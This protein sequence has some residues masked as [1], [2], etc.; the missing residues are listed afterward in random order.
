MGFMKIIVACEESQA[1]T[2]AFRSRGHEAYS[3]DLQECSGGYPEWHIQ[4]DALSI[5]YDLSYKWDMMIA[6]PPC[7]YLTLTG[8]RWFNRDKFRWKAV[9][10]HILRERAKDFF[11]KLWEAPISKI[12]IENPMGYMNPVL[13]HSQI[14]QPFYFGE[15]F[16]KQTCLWIKN[17]PLL[18]H[19]EQDT[20]FGDKQSHVDA[21]EFLYCTD[22]K[23]GKLKKQP[24]W[25]AQA[26]NIKND[27]NH[28]R[29]KIR[30]KTFDGI[31][32]AMAEQWG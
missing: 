31:A 21:G 18:R 20:L 30:S 7:T 2:K 4:G 5:V 12:A 29:A 15:S 11:W 16:S 27:N 8:N 28:T 10:R 3:C 22:K 6:H 1:V 25:Y 23:T 19:F 26:R 13:K 14:I 24:L 32:R 17:L 9:K